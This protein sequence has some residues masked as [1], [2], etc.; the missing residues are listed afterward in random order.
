VIP[1]LAEFRW[2]QALLHNQRAVLLNAALY[3]R[4]D[5]KI[6]LVTVPWFLDA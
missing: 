4:R 2:Y 6:I 3:L 5:P 1:N